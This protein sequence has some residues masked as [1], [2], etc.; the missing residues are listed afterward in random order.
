MNG[1][2][3]GLGG[4]TDDQL[5]EMARHVGAEITRRHPSV[6]DA[7]TDAIRDEIAAARLSQD[8]QWA[9]KKWLALAVSRGLGKGWTIRTWRGET[10]TLRCYLQTQGLI[11]CLH[12][13]G[14]GAHPPGSLTA[15][16][17]RKAERR[18][19]T[20]VR[21]IAEEAARQ[22]PDGETVDCDRAAATSYDTPPLP[23]PIERILAEQE[24]AAA[25]AAARASFRESV[26][27]RED[28]AVKAERERLVAVH[29]TRPVMNKHKVE[30]GREPAAPREAMDHLKALERV[31]DERIREAMTTWDDGARTT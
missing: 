15:E 16:V 25:R 4:L 6:A 12:V 17:G 8:S 13:T 26:S 30:V 7:A 1:D 3:L 5:V 19:E 21:L 23:Q 10:G 20:L 29:G 27:A 31:R 18:D 14:D 2:P 28:A 24:A 9:T 22:W 11:Y